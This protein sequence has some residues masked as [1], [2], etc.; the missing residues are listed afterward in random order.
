MIDLLPAPS[1]T[2]GYGTKPAPSP[3]SIQASV[4]NTEQI[5][6]SQTDT[7]DV[8][9][10]FNTGVTELDSLLHPNSHLACMD[11]LV[12]P[13]LQELLR[14]AQSPVYQGPVTSGFE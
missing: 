4:G 9:R 7:S 8:L 10:L 2:V 14:H 11:H 3:V 12:F 6:A 1:I 13:V 5:Q